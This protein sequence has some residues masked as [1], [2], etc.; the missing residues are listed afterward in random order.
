MKAQSIRF[1]RFSKH[2]A[3]TLLIAISFFLNHASANP[4][5]RSTTEMPERGICA[6]RG[7]SQSHPENTILAFEE[8]IRLGVHMIEFDV[9]MTKDKKLVLMHDATIDRTTNGSGKVS[10]HTLA[11]LKA[12]DAGVYKGEQ[13]A[14]TK[15][16]T[17]SETLAM[18]PQN[19]WLNVH[20]K[21]EEQLAVETAKVIYA[22]KREHQCFLACSEKAINAA[23]SNW[24][25]IKHCNMDRQANNLQ[26]VEQTIGME[27]EFIQL[28]GGKNANPEH[29]KTAIQNQIRVNFCCTNSAEVIKSLFSAGIQFPLV[30]DAAGMMK[31]A[32]SLGIPKLK[33]SYPSDPR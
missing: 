28:L 17:L 30:D 25:E 24:P 19:I 27:A 22:H 2:I 6:H 3:I 31:V 12:L 11:E 32:E 4:N 33:P 15:I 23:R 14:G 10:D 20:L 16:P 26:Y 8:A 7:A 1:S 13:F 29:V 9:A 21:G 5:H 18:M